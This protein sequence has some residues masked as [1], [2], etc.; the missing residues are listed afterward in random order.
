MKSEGRGKVKIKASRENPRL[1]WGQCCTA[2][3]QSLPELDRPNQKPQQ[4]FRLNVLSSSSLLK[5][6]STFMWL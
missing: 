1:P 4:H 2:H 3:L 6:R 5:N